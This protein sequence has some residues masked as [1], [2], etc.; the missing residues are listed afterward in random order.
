MF[1][2]YGGAILHSHQNVLSIP[3]TPH[4]QRHRVSVLVLVLITL[5]DVLWYF[6]V[7]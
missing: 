2:F 1:N 5:M 3:V 4:P 6:I 7:I